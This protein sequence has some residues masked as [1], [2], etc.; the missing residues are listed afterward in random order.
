[1]KTAINNLVNSE[2][3]NK[4]LEHLYR[5][6]FRW[7]DEREYENFDEYIKNAKSNIK[8]FKI[9]KML[10]SFTIFFNLNNMGIKIKLLSTKWTISK[11]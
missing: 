6:K 7:Q 4:D 1:M 8:S 9:D 3:F 5:L 11:A 10:K 2:Q